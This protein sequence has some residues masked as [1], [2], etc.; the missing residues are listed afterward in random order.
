MKRFKDYRIVLVFLACVILAVLVVCWVGRPKKINA[1]FN[2]NSDEI[3]FIEV[4]NDTNGSVL[5]KE[6][7][8]MKEFCDYLSKVEF[9]KV[10]LKKAGNEPVYRYII[11]GND[12]KVFEIAFY[13]NEFC[14]FGNSNYRI[15]GGVQDTFQ[16]ITNEVSSRFL[17]IVF[18]YEDEA[19]SQLDPDNDLYTD[20]AGFEAAVSDSIF[21]QEEAVNDFLWYKE[22][23][24]NVNSLV[25]KIKFWP[26]TVT[27]I[28]RASY[29]DDTTIISTVNLNK[30]LVESGSTDLID[31][32]AKVLINTDYYSMHE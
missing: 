8:F 30:G 24:S 18:E 27:P 3:T 16:G 29:H 20:R 22:F 25:I 9:D 11:H 10:S 19:W 15:K 12:G 6:K 28:N 32:I 5:I 7:D 21:R 26:G 2:N 31:E 4:I 17:N 13:N 23:G 1:F 14:R